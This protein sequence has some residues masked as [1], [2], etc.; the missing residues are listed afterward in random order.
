M[1]WSWGWVRSRAGDVRQAH[2]R[3]VEVWRCAIRCDEVQGWVKAGGWVTGNNRAWEW[4]DGG[5]RCGLLV[6]A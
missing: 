6:W 1:R 3:A 5:G 2:L 4:E